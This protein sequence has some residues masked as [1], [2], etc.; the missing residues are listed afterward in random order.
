MMPTDLL[1]R[2]LRD[3]RISVTDRCNMRCSYCM[4][5]EFF[6]PDYAFLERKELLTYEEIT[7]VTRVFVRLGVQK[8]R[9][10]GGEPLLRRELSRL[11]SRLASVKGIEDLTLT[12]NGLLL[13]RHARGL[14]EA[15][16]HRVTVSLD[17][18]DQEE[19][20]SIANVEAPVEEVLSGIREA[21]RVGLT[22]VKINAVIR[23]GIN[24]KAILQLAAFFRGSGCVLRFIEY[25][26]VGNANTWSLE[27]TVTKREILDV[28]QSHFPLREIGRRDL[29]APAVDYEF[30]DGKGQVGVIGS[31]TESFCSSCTRARLTADGKLV[32]CLFA[33]SGHDLKSLLRKGAGDA[34]ILEAITSIWSRRV[35]RY[36]DLRW[37][38][39]A[40]SESYRPKDH[41]KIEMITLGG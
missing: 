22:P 11:V 31:V 15:G 21:Q 37:E 35:D 28:I 23:R 32:T 10:T 4:P 29:R 25:M 2:S 13:K 27:K 3:L 39:L 18:L 33:S 24:E 6:G 36:S 41:E 1:G 20:A 40:S 9:I 5:K 16:L 26:D 7:R 17:S 34:E 30:I 19:F 8:V 14:K 38:Q 12:T